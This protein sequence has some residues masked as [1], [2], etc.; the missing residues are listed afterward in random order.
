VEI[1]FAFDIN[2]NGANGVRSGD[3]RGNVP[4]RGISHVRKTPNEAHWP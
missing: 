4:T 3:R 1:A 2:P